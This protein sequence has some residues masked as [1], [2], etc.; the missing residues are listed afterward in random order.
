MFIYW[1]HLTRIPLSHISLEVLLLS[2]YFCSMLPIVKMQLM[3]SDISFSNIGKI[4]EKSHV[5]E[6]SRMLPLT[7]SQLEIIY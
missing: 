6:F 1:I 7:T 4:N 3:I 2:S 5:T